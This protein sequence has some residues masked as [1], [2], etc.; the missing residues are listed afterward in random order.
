MRGCSRP[1][2]T[3]AYITIVICT[4]YTSALY[5]CLCQWCSGGGTW[6]NAV[7]PLFFSHSAKFLQDC[8][9]CLLQYPGV[10]PLHFLGLDHCSGSCVSDSI[11]RGDRVVL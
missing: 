1:I 6:G 7:P 4:V 11:P 3:V 9:F 10:P 2:L 8:T 5:S